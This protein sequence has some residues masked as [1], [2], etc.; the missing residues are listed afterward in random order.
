[1]CFITH[2]DTIVEAM[3]TGSKLFEAA[4]PHLAINAFAIALL[5][6]PILPSVLRLVAAACVYISDSKSTAANQ[7]RWLL[8]RVV[9]PQKRHVATYSR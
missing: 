1:M 7:A 4:S 5:S 2:P 8:S 6:Q 3:S 9:T